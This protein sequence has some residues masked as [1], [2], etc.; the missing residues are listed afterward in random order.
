MKDCN[1]YE[2]QESNYSKKLTARNPRETNHYKIC[3]NRIAKDEQTKRYKTY[4]RR[5][6]RQRQSDEK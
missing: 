6:Y 5:K 3:Y 1:L 2:K 4:G